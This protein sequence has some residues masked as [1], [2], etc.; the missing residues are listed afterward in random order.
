L[1]VADL[2]GRELERQL[3]G[4]GIRL[5]TGPVVTRI[6]SRLPA[7]VEG[8]ALHYADY[9]TD[10]REGFADFRVRIGRPRN[11]RRWLQPQAYFLFDGHAPFAPLPLDQGFPMLEWGLNWCVS[12]HCHQYLIFHAAAIEKAGRTLVLPA[13]PG[14]GKSTLCA[15]LVHRGW[16]LLSDELTLID[17]GTCSVV[18]LPRPVSLKNASI[19]VIRDFA[20]DAEIGVPVHDTTKGSVAHMRVPTDSVHRAGETA[21]PGWMVLP[22]Y[23]AGASARLRPLSRARGLMKLAENAFNYNV[24]GRRGFDLLARFVDACGC[25]EFAYGDL[26]EATAVFDDLAAGR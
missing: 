15:G 16:R 22:S 5:R 18:P 8:I 3:A 19:D 23:Q 9:P 26:G 12:A 7:V 4:P 20:P 1:I 2:S 24:H 10:D 25:Y 6:Q 11:L 17:F 13:P 21:L 14:T